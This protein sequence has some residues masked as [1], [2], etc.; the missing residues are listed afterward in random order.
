MAILPPDPVYC[1]REDMGHIHSLSFCVR[2]SNFVSHILAGTEKGTVY[3]WDL[4]TNRLQ[5]KQEMGK[6]IQALHSFDFK[7]VTQEKEGCLKLWSVRKSS[8]EPEKT[9]T[10]GAGFGKSILVEEALVVPQENGRVDVVDVKT[11]ETIR[12]LAP[13]RENLGKIMAL[14]EVTIGSSC[15]IMAGYETGD[16]VLWDMNTFRPCGHL[17]L[18]DQLTSITYDPVSRRAVA[19]G[20]SKNLQLFTVDSSYEMAVKL[21][22]SI[23]NEGCNVVKLRPDQKIL[24]AGCWD[25]K[26]R[27]FSWK[28]LRLLAVLAEH[29]ESITDV[30]F[31]PH[32]VNYWKSNIM[33]SSSSDGLIALWNI[34]N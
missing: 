26:V 16:V 23:T 33:A 25:G 6:S 13:D 15:C 11:F 7:I 9:L 21:E 28:T 20:A 22:I 14:E 34:Y 19:G 10:C 3:F 5:H 18:Q 17:K 1:F 4:E 2:S 30:K 24:V 12:S 29:K 8:Y 31:S 27:L 32:P